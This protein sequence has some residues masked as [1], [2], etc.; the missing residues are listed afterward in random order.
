MSKRI[1]PLFLALVLGF[2]AQAASAEALLRSRVV[3]EG[4]VVTMGDLFDNSG[5]KASVVVMRAP[6]PGMRVSVDA[7]WLSH[8]AM[9]NGLSWHPRGLFEEASITRAGI[10]IEREQIL[11]SLHKA[12]EAKETPADFQIETD[13]NLRPV[14]VP[15]GAPAQLQVRD[16]YYNHQDRRFTATLTVPQDGAD[17]SRIMVSGRLVT[18]LQVP[19]LTHAIERGEVIMAAD[20]G[21]VTMRETDI[22]AN[23]ARDPGQLVGMTFK[24]QSARPGQ[25]VQLTDLQKP[26][27]VTRGA[28]VT[29]V[30]QHGGMTLTAQ[31]RAMDQGSMGDVI[32]VTNSHSNTTVEAT[33]VGANQVRVTL[34]GPIALAN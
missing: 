16:L 15:V 33:I 26:L 20:L 32:R 31:G 21:S 7:D 17:L 3:V 11:A 8:V 13:N 27:A 19:V 14:M 4:P 6:A 12:L 5:D 1:V 34:G 2:A 29:M 25:P 9:I 22:R 18:T 24:Q 28:Q 30:L 23:I 10:P